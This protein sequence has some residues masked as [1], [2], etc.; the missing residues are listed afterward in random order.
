MYNNCISFIHGF[1]GVSV[2]T[3]EETYIP[4]TPKSNL[5]DKQLR[6]RTR[7]FDEK[8]DTIHVCLTENN[9][10]DECAI[11]IEEIQDGDKCKILQCNHVYHENCI[12]KWVVFKNKQTCPMCNTFIQGMNES[13]IKG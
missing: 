8:Y 5:S 11:C 1:F 6:Q 13:I 2:A 4:N 7:S 12:K 9:I 10:K 3:E